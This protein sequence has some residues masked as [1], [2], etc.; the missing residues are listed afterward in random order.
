MMPFQLWT[1]FCFG[2]GAVGLLGF[3]FGMV[4]QAG[5]RPTPTRNR[6]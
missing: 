1:A 5:K 3:L 2:I 6:H 4:R